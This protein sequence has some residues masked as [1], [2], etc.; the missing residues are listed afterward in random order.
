MRTVA[1]ISGG[2]DSCYNMMQCV[3]AGHDI[4]A[5]A[6]LQPQHKDELDSY[7]YQTV[8]HQGI[9]MYADAM[10]LPLY[11]EVTSGVAI[12]KGRNYKPTVNDEVED[13]YRLLS[14][15]KEEMNIQAVSSGAILSDYQRIRV[16]NVCQRLGLV[17][18]A[19][20][21]RRNQKELLQEM[22]SSGVHA[23]LIKVAALGLDP[24]KHLGMTLKDIQPHLLVMQETYGLN[25]CGEGGEYET[26]TL[27]CPLFKKRLVI[28][29]KELIIHSDDSVA[30]VG[31]LNLKCHLEPKDDYDGT[32]KLPINVKNSF[33][34]VKDLSD[35]VFSDISDIDLSESELESI[36]KLEIEEKKKQEELNPLINY[37]GRKFLDKNESV[38]HIE[39]D[40]AEDGYY[41]DEV[42]NESNKFPVVDHRS[43]FGNKHGWFYIGGIVG[44]GSDTALAT[45]DAMRKLIS[46]LQSENLELSNV[47]SVNLYMRD[48]GHYAA[49]NEVYVNTFN[50]PNP[51]TR[52]CVQ[53]PLPEDVGLIMDAVAYRPIRNPNNDGDCTNT[54][55]RVTMHV[56]G[57]SHWAPANIGPYS[58]AIKVGEIV[59]TCGQ[60]ALVP[61]T[62]KLVEGGARA[63]CALALRH[64]TRV[65]RASHPRAT[66]RSGAREARRQL[67]RRTAGAMVQCAVV[68]ALPR[69][70][71]LDGHNATLWFPDEAS[72]R[73]H[74]EVASRMSRDELEQVLSYAVEKL[75]R[76]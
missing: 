9:E 3:V 48:M 10:E 32:I 16:E 34:F 67:E 40:V 27:D 39:D 24:M 4:V 25:V 45:G 61:G 20:L 50:F 43:I 1:L 6:N 19:Y 2:K 74:R 60:I 42:H 47:C 37:E 29:E 28:D 51:P 31:Y 13:L 53:C 68:D 63:Q 59:G 72:C 76:S 75:E 64:L 36:E 58:Q 26:F 23:I 54:K 57:I 17:S 52:V 73:S 46:L 15:I 62:M 14:R 12:D 8:G 66:I 55:E 11:R 65:L 38:D 69:G 21:W 22:V 33:E 35:T 71:A 7:M 30:S 44:E 70:A 49:L 5:L 41:Y 18:L 56:Q